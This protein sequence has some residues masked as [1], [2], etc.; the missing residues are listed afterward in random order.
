MSI[1]TS[2]IIFV[3]SAIIGAVSICSFIALK[4]R[5][6]YEVQRYPVRQLDNESNTGKSFKSSFYLAKLVFE[7]PEIS[8][9][10]ERNGMSFMTPGNHALNSRRDISKQQ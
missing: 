10:I 5:K 7:S 1:I 2:Q 9:P 4:L 6:C 8:W 3:I